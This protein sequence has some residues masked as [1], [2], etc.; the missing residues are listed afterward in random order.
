MPLDRH[1]RRRTTTVPGPKAPAGYEPKLIYP[2]RPL[3]LLV[4]GGSA[5]EESDIEQEKEKYWGK[6][7]PIFECS[8]M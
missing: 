4:D 3:R 6:N 5:R 1:Q 2:L 8:V 7:D